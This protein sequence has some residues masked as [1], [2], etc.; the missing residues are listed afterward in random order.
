M[1]REER[2]SPEERDVASRITGTGT[3][4]PVCRT[5]EG[6]YNSWLGKVEAECREELRQDDLAPSA[7]TERTSHLLY[8]SPLRLFISQ[9]SSGCSDHVIWSPKRLDGKSLQNHHADSGLIQKRD[10]NSDCAT[11]IFR[12]IIHNVIQHDVEMDAT[13]PP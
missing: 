2:K 12:T 13:V 10:Q 9:L 1:M 8:F 11:T 3:C 6:R 4:L 7:R 5:A